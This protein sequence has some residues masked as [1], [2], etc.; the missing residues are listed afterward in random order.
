MSRLG[1]ALRKALLGEVVVAELGHIS[2]GLSPDGT[3]L[4]SR[5]RVELVRLHGRPLVRLA[6]SWLS[7]MQD[8]YLSLAG[9]SSL[10]TMLD[11]ALR[12]ADE[13]DGRP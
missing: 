5:I 10:R 13:D 4:G 2:D 9:A 3:G 6:P 12:L 11:E 1:R 8:V 7:H